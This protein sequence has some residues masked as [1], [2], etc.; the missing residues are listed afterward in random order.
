MPAKQ[1]SP[2][3]DFGR[4]DIQDGEQRL[5]RSHGLT[6]VNYLWALLGARVGRRRAAYWDNSR[7][8]YSLLTPTIDGRSAPL[9]P[10]RRRG[11]AVVKMRGRRRRGRAWAFRPDLSRR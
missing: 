3:V 2:N 9:G 5:R 8:Q 11:V 7:Q 1:K 4:E 10:G 6:P